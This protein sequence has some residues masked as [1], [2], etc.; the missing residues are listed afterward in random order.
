MVHVRVV[1]SDGLGPGGALKGG[2]FLPEV[3][4]HRVGRRVTIVRPPM[5][6][7]ARDDVDSRRLL[8]QN[9]GLGGAKLRVGEIARRKITQG[10]QAI[11]RLIPARDAMRADNRGGVFFV[12]RHSDPLTPQARP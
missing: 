12:V 11:Q 10:N 9:R 7:T 1:P 5:H 4:Q 8:F 2:D 3:V 6:L